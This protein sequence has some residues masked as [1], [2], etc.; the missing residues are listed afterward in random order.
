MIDDAFKK[1]RES[2]RAKMLKY[3]RA[4]NEG[5]STDEI[6]ADEERAKPSKS[7]DVIKKRLEK[8]K[9]A[10][11]GE[12]KKERFAFKKDLID[13]KLEEKTSL[14]KRLFAK[15]KKKKN[16]PKASS[17]KPSQNLK[18]QTKQ[19]VSLNANPAKQNL[20][21]NTL[22]TQNTPNPQRVAKRNLE[23]IRLHSPKAQNGAKT[24]PQKNS[25][26]KSQTNSHANSPTNSPMRPSI[27]SQAN[28]QTRPQT[29]LQA[30]LQRLRSSNLSTTQTSEAKTQTKPV[31]SAQNSAPLKENLAK[32]AE[33]SALNSP[34][35]VQAR[36][37]PPIQ[38]KINDEDSVKAKNALL[39]GHS[40]ATQDEKNLGKN[41]LLFAALCIVFAVVV[42]VPKIY[43]T[44]NIY[45]LSRDIAALRTQESVLSEENKE[46]NKKLENM[47]FQNQILDYLE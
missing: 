4:V 34:N 32:K 27:N 19:S 26:E 12:E 40:K 24:N 35:L 41:Q 28:S 17:A 44:S 21:Q 38:L 11:F 13:V 36:Q 31:N 25:Q 8:D 18:A 6:L 47:R 45:Y 37:S 22:K 23:D 5:K 7:D 9:K 46:L 42:F 14:A 39:Q 1:E 30:N 29:T 20:A 33:N 16:T 3:S 10:A 15:F 43:I 2:I